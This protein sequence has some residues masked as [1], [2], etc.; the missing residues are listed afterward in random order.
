M[1]DAFGD[2]AALEGVAAAAVSA[3]NA[4]DALLWDRRLRTGTAELVQL[5]AASE[6]RA[7]AAMDGA[8]LPLE[9]VRSGA[10]LDE[11]PMGLT[12]AAAM[13]VTAQARDQAKV[14]DQAP[15]QFIAGLALK[16]GRDFLPPDQLGQPRFTDDVDDPIRLGSLPPVE[17]V[18]PR[19]GGLSRLVAGET[20]APAIVV[21]A[22][23]H[24][25]LLALRPF[26]FGSGLVAR[27]SEHALL[28]A[29]G[30]DPS[31]IVA[32][33]AG[34]MRLGRPAYVSAARAYLSATADGVS[35]WVCHICTAFELSVAE[36]LE[37]LG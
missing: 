37:Y 25:E 28:I 30:V 12:L 5:I 3:R 10:A 33:S 27:A 26:G 20:T 23:V 1:N 24:G 9:L 19:L 13:R 2:V 15:L 7:S 8:D 6:A 22:L 31:A 21:A 16:A 4:V 18:L 17:Q 32:P 35:E 11:T 36:S 34:L 29:R 14:V